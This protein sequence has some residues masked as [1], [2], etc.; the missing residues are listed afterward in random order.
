MH[1][2][3]INL[4]SLAVILWSGLLII[5]GSVL[6]LSSQVRHLVELLESRPPT[7]PARV[8]ATQPQSP[9]PRV[10]RQTRARAGRDPRRGGSVAYREQ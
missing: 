9:R 4:T 3:T 5:A 6:I 7:E 1:G 10:A 8:V 2:L